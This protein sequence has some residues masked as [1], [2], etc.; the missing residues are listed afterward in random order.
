MP[1]Y[2]GTRLQRGQG[3]G[4][5][6]GGLFCSVLPIIKKIAPMIGRKVLQTGVQIVDDVASCQSF[7]ESA[8][9]R[10][11]DAINKGINKIVLAGESQSGS[12]FR[13]KRR[14][15]TSAKKHC[16]RRTSDILL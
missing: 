14:L 15:Q 11:I 12:G 13:R 16:K 8:K 9:T 6:F 2:Q 3:L 7:K 1:F 4:S 5:I 10:I